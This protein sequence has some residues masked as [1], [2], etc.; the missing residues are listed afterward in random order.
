MTAPTMT[1]SRVTGGKTQTAPPDAEPRAARLGTSGPDRETK[2]AALQDGILGAMRA[3]ADVRVAAQSASP[4]RRRRTRA[5]VAP[6]A[7]A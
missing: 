6:R 1:R 2:V 5:M 3:L 4:G 7:P